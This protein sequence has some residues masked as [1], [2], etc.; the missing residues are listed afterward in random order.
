M[1]TSDQLENWLRL[2][3]LPGIGA[4]SVEKLVSAYSNP[5]DILNASTH[6]W[7][8]AGIS[9]NRVPSLAQRDVDISA[10]L[11]WL[12]ADDHHI[13]TL[14]DP[15]YPALL[16]HIDP[17]PPLL[18]VYGDL[19]MLNHPQLAI[20]GSRNPSSAGL[21]NTAAF[22]EHLATQGLGITSGLAIGVDGA[23][24]EAALKANGLTIAVAATGLDQVYPARHQNLAR[25]IVEQG[26]IVSEFPIGTPPLASNFPRRNRIVSG[27]CLGT[28][29]VE[30][31]LKSGSLITAR[32]ALSQG[33]ELFAI[34]GSIHNPL[35]RGCHQLIRQGAK[36]VETAEDILEDLGPLLSHFQLPKVSTSPEKVSEDSLEPNPQEQNLLEAVDFE[37]TAIDT[38]ITRT[39]LAAEEVSSTLLIM[40]LNGQVACEKGGYYVRLV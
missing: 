12:E 13:I 37:P 11:K 27:L 38:I 29:V 39:G 35:A 4:R 9:V 10:D 6:D 34:P 24:H 14:E 26:A 20:V 32:C 7:Q 1:T 28:L 25:R 30:G 40:E 21:A 31:A 33:R 8:R 5:A 19:S 3:K 18:Y 23:A 17:P 15:E 22:A 36:L 2:I 16:T